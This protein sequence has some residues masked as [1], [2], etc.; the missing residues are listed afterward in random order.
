MPRSPH[1]AMDY[2]NLDAGIDFVTTLLSSITVHAPR[3]FESALAAAACLGP[4]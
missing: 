2:E 3:A 1:G 4:P